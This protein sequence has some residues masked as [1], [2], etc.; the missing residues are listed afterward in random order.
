MR[1]RAIISPLI[2]TRERDAVSQFETVSCMQHRGYGAP[3]ERSVSEGDRSSHLV[4]L[5]PISL[6][7]QSGEMGA[8]PV[9]DLD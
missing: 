1:S 3:E 6:A 8:A 2:N 9:V 4:G 5:I 7:T